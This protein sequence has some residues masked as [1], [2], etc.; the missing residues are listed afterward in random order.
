MQS[1]SYAEAKLT[2]L[3]VRSRSLLRKSHMLGIPAPEFQLG[4]A[5]NSSPNTDGA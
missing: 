5:S 3:T 1:V 2:L 4:S